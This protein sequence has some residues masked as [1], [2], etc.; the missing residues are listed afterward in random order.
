MQAGQ[1]NKS[2]KACLRS[3]RLKKFEKGTNLD[4][5]SNKQLKDSTLNNQTSNEY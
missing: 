2:K 1:D 5:F 4:N 3:A